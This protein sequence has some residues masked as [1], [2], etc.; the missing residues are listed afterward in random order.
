[1]IGG[2]VSD[3]ARSLG[4]VLAS[5][6]DA[7]QSG[8]GWSA[9]VWPTGFDPLDT[10]VGGGLRA[11][12]LTLIGGPQGLGKTTFV[13]QMARN[14]AAA[15]K[16]AYFLCYEHTE[17]HLLERLI[18]LEAAAI[19]GPDGITLAR[20]RHVLS[21][22]EE[23]S[24][25]NLAER[26]AGVG[27]G[28]EAVQSLGSFSD[29]LVL[30]TSA[31]DVDL[32]GVRALAARA[33]GDGAVLFVD[34]LQKIHVGGE[35]QAEHERVSLVVEALK[36]LALEHGIAVVAIVAADSEG[37]RER[38][39]RLHHLRGSSSL[40]YEADVVLMMNDKFSIVARHHLVYDSPNA[41][42]FRDYVILTI[43]KNRSGLDNID[44]QFRKEY[45]HSR[46]DPAGSVVREQLVDERVYVE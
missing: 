22:T 39:T 31:A 36:D 18:A 1:M 14:I 12:E 16:S 33:A 40:A 46:L 44:L 11:G 23:A 45:A 5:A 20:V 8:R 17:Q 9:A 2:S 13:L 25:S 15:G 21:Q 43:E 3:A 10:Y 27:H 32:D 30:V 38:R 29:R 28:S 34:Y 42:R 24:G 7:L 4:E 6:N 37:L 26:L 19:G 35:P 41:D